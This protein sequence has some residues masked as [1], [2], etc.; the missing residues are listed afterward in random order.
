MTKPLS[1]VLLASA[2]A[3]VSAVAA[4][5]PNH[6][7]GNRGLFL[8]DKLGGQVRLLDPVTYKERS[9]I[10][11]PANPHD[12]VL[13]ADHKLAYVPIYGDGIYGRNANPGHEIAIIDT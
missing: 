4:S 7:T 3:V 1:I 10:K 9:A 6:P 8:V 5:D 11:L 12:F 13:T 2:M